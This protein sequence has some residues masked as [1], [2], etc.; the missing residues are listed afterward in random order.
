MLKWTKFQ[1]VAPV[2]AVVSI[3]CIIISR[4]PTLI[5]EINLWVFKLNLNAGYIVVFSIPIL[6]FLLFWLWRNKDQS[7]LRL[8]IFIKNRWL[9]DLMII[10]PALASIFMLVQYFLLL[11]PDGLCNTFSI[12]HYF[13]D[14]NYYG[15]QPEYCMS[16]TDET[17]KLMPYIY[18]PVQVWGYIIFVILSVRYD[19]LLWRFYR[20]I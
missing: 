15:I 2:A 10:I 1:V 16:L 11:R 17:Q 4:A 3:A 7:I 20:T 9:L 5:D 13:W 8:E 12:H 19:F 18:P 6:F 14:F